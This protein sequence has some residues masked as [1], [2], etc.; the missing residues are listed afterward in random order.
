MFTLFSAIRRLGRVGGYW[1]R[2]PEVDVPD[3]S[4]GADEAVMLLN[5]L[6]SIPEDIFKVMCRFV[7]L[8]PDDV[9]DLFPESETLD[10]WDPDHR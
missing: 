5:L 10:E 8:N 6:W 9:Y 7:G 1:S 3:W 4:S 2:R